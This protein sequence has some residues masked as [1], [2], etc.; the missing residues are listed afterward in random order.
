MVSVVF[1]GELVVMLWL[2]VWLV[3][4]V[5]VFEISFIEYNGHS[6][7]EYWKFNDGNSFWT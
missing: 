2:Y 3:V 4:I 6:E 5:L 7:N 1:L